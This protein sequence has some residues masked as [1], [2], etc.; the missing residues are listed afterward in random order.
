MPDRIDALGNDDS[1]LAAFSGKLL[2]DAPD[3]ALQ[4]LVEQAAQDLNAPIALV[5]LVLSRTQL[6]RAHSGLPAELAVAR[7][8]DRDLSFCQFVVR[9]GTPFEVNDAPRDTRVPQGLVGLHGIK[10]YLGMPVKANGEVVGSMCVIDTAPRAFSDVE[11]AALSELSERVSERLSALAH[12]ADAHPSALDVSALTPA[13]AEMRNLLVPLKSGVALA[14]IV[15]SELA[16]LARLA[17]PSLTDEQ[18]GAAVRTLSSSLGAIDQLRGLHADLATAA[19][20]LSRQIFAVEVASLDANDSGDCDTICSAAIGLARHATKLVGGVRFD[21]CPALAVATHTA[22]ATRVVAAALAVVAT[23]ARSALSQSGIDL[24][25]AEQ[26]SR[27]VVSI[28]APDVDLSGAVAEI[29]PLIEGEAAV[30]VAAADGRVT[31]RFWP[32]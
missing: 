14:R 7:A 15:A 26:G 29:Q 1:R 16:P 6:F 2:D 18:C 31:L 10:A 8:T 9:D 32:R 21:G 22:T 20:A 27:V 17:D 13:F 30:D 12:A 3:D 28:A 19:A 25:V 5:S 4:E 11:R 24:S 23:V